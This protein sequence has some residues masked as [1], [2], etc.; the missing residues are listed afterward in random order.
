MR[1]RNALLVS[2]TAASQLLAQGNSAGWDPAEILKSETYVKPPANIERMIMAPRVDISFNAPNAD[3]SWFV[4]A[5]GPTRG[6][7]AAYG[8]P[9]IYL[10]GLA[11]DTKA[12]R[13]RALTLETATK[14]SLVNPRTGATKDI[15]A[16]KGATISG[17]S[18]SP[19]GKSIAFIANFDSGSYAYVADVATGKTAQASKAALNGAFVTT[20]EWSADSKSLVAVLIPDGRG[21]VPTHGPGGI[22][23]GPTVRATNSRAVPTPVYWSLLLDPHEKAML[24]YYTTGQLAVIDVAKKTVKKIGEPRMIRSVESSHDAQY[25]TVT[26]MTEPFSYLVQVNAFGSVR[27]LWDS[28][29]KTISTLATTRLREGNDD[30]GGDNP[31]GGRGG[32]A[33]SPSDTGKRNVAWNP[34]GP[35][36]VYVQSVFGAAPAGG[37]AAAPAAGGRGG[38]G[39]RGGGAGALAGAAARPQPTSVQYVNWLPPFGPT[40][41]KVLYE[42]S[43]QL[44]AIVYSTDQKT[45]FASDSGAVFAVRLADNKRFNLGRGITLS[46][47]GGGGFGGRGGGGG[48]GGNDSTGGALITR[49]IGGKGFVVLGKDGKTVAVQGTRAPGANW[50][51]QAPRPWADKLDIETGTRTRIFDSPAN[52]YDTFVSPLDDDYSSFLYTHESPTTIRDVWM[53]DVAAGTTKKVTANVDVGPEV[54]GAISKRFQVTRPRDGNKMW[55]DVLLPRDWAPGKKYPGVLWFYPRE[56]TS[57]AQYEQSRVGTNIN[58]FPEVPSA[59]P[60]SSM[61]LWVAAGYALIQ[62]DI[63]IWGDSGKMNDNYTRDLRENLDAV[64]DAVV[65]MGYVDRDHMGIGGHSYGAFSTMNAISLV[66]WFKGAIAGD[67]MYN[68]TLT[69]FGFQSERRSFYQ[70]QDTYLDMSPFFR[71]DKIVTPLLMYHNWEDQNTGTSII[72]SQR[73][74]AALQGLGKNAVLFEYPYEDHSVGAYA[75]DLDQWARWVAWFDIYVKGAKPTPKPVP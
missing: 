3:R 19:D 37:G 11:V 16:P 7:I 49:S 60:A 4:R 71:A 34:V 27:E 65:E 5:V 40:D 48:G 45:L 47:G 72:S 53:K 29:G 23:D 1:F 64:L 8:K 73:M 70:A 24:K 61:Q 46:A 57:Q 56:Y 22:E 43:A 38:R 58:T 13:A 42:G 10:G 31:G 59:R 25:F 62:P 32:P 68:R 21:P 44:G 17:Q 12:N 28:N 66:P 2:F 75:S 74:F 55:V 54:S 18:W 51:T 6:D 20:I 26:S 14:L 50:N 30:A 67:G 63:P 35:G 15:D 52:G 41:T 9:H 36:L 33:S 39:G 69:P